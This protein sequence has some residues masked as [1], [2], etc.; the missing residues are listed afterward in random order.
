A[1]MDQTDAEKAAAEARYDTV[2]AEVQRAQAALRTAEIQI[3][4][5]RIKA[6]WNGGGNT[7][8]VGE[9]FVEE[10]NLL[11]PNHPILT[12]LD[13][14]TVI[15][16]IDVIESD[17]AKVK[18]GMPATVTTDMYPDKVFAG[19]LSRLAPILRE[20]SRQARAEIDIPNPSGSLKPGMFVEVRLEFARHED[21]LAV[22]EAAVVEKNGKKGVFL[23]DETAMTADFI[24]ITA[25]IT[26]DGFTEVLEPSLDG[27]VV[28]LGQEQLQDG[29]SVILPAEGGQEKTSPE[30]RP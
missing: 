19:K 10:G 21:A 25:G 29:S 18:K 26:Y 4:Y 11:S 6:E 16:E 8:V 3:S 7:R 28:I 5:T 12:L 30:G 2:L 13:I 14:S 15:A 23:V 27:K 24:P 17:Y 20:E 9:R 1:V 22:P